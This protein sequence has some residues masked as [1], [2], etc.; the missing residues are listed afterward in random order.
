MRGLQNTINTS[1]TTFS[2]K[3]KK[4]TAINNKGFINAGNTSNNITTNYSIAEQS[5]LTSNTL[6]YGATT[7]L[8]TS[9][10]K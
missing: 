7:D 5:T 1:A 3:L 2:S 9:A 8:T 6:Q 4:P 10:L